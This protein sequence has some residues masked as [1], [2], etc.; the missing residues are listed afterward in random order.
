M[1]IVVAAVATHS[2]VQRTA[3]YL[4]LLLVLG[5]VG[6]VGGVAVTR[7]MSRDV[8]DLDVDDGAARPVHPTAPV[9]ETDDPTPAAGPTQ[10]IR[11]R[12][13]PHARPDRA[14][15]PPMSW[16]T[17]LD[18]IG[19]VC[20]LLGA[21]LCLAGAIGLLRFPDTL[22]RL[23]AATKPQTLGLILVLTGLAATLRTWSAVTTLVLLAATQFFTSPVTA[24]LVGRAAYRNGNVDESTLEVDELSDALKRSG[25]DPRKMSH[26]AY[27]LM[28]LTSGGSARGSGASSSSRSPS[29]SCGSSAR[30]PSPPRWARRSTTGSSAP[31][32]GRCCCGAAPCSG[33]SSSARSPGRCGAST[34][35]AD[36]PY[37]ALWRSW[38]DE[39]QPVH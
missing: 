39:P 35:S 19:A 5:F 21:M 27:L 23:H 29:G 12:V 8:D 20:L 14:G 22:S 18:G 17:A 16:A 1:V 28:P 24:H 30:R 36:G 32:P 38:R 33:S 11:P 10:R 25:R 2:A 26:A 7:F 31:T 15:G 9:D 34:P 3:T 37:A 13:H 6:F 4:T